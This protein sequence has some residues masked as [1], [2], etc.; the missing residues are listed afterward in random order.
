MIHYYGL[1]YGSTTS[2]LYEYDNGAPQELARTIS[3][4]KVYN[5]QIVQYGD[6]A[7]S[8]RQG[9][10]V[11]SPKREFIANH[12]MERNGVCCTS[13]IANTMISML[14]GQQDEMSGSHI[15]LTVPNG[16][17][18]ADY[19]AM[20]N[21]VMLAIDAV[22]PNCA[23][24][25]N[26][27]LLPEPVAA[28]LHYIH[29]YMK[30]KGD[31]ENR[32]F[33]VCD[34]GGGTTDMSIVTCSR[35]GRSLRFKVEPNQQSDKKLGGNDF[36]NC[37]CRHLGFDYRTISDESKNAIR[38]LKHQLSKHNEE[39]VTVGNTT[40]TCTRDVFEESIVHELDRLGTLMIDLRN[41]CGLAVD[42]DWVI[43][44]VGGS[45]R[46]PAVQNTLHK[47]FPEVEQ[48][49]NTEADDIFYSVAQG[50]S[51]YSA[52]RAGVLA[53]EYD[54]IEIEN[55]TPHSISYKTA[56]GD[57]EVIVPQNSPDGL[58]GSPPLHL[59]GGK[60]Y[61]D[62]TYSTGNIILLEESA[63]EPMIWPRNKE[64]RFVLGDR[65]IMDVRLKLSIDI[66]N[67]RIFSCTI[68]DI[69]TGEDNTWTIR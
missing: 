67:S 34:I 39:R 8:T 43:L 40:C 22:T 46:I 20:H 16:Y 12:D 42:K 28:A 47:Y 38:I 52:Y 57:W 51:I 69:Q 5:G 4:T 24:S 61:S 48:V 14:K 26:I 55:A 63:S 2:L 50:A 44:R 49:F 13:M 17:T 11:E 64:K 7:Y 6:E 21:I 3:A 25:V 27:H 30:E 32:H 18:A 59:I 31:F 56:D 41:N 29:C 15:T 54:S 62:G 45:C 33:V 65:N 23:A 37:L 66:K 36:D 68:T 19:I 10:L 35:H 60:K 1:D 58:H 9:Y 53:R